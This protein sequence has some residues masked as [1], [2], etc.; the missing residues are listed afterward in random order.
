MRDLCRSIS[1]YGARELSNR[2]SRGKFFKIDASPSATTTMSS[3]QGKKR[4]A[5]DIQPVNY[6]E[7]SSRRSSK[8]VSDEKA[9]K[10]R[11]LAEAEA[12][13]QMAIDEVA[14]L[15]KAARQKTRGRL[16][17]PGA[18]YSQGP[19]VK[20]TGGKRRT[21]AVSSDDEGEWF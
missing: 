5:R 20:N 4:S 14:A 13:D 19:G 8:E 15:E 21:A 2:R 6:S 3:S 9:A 7:T 11:A 1:G 16:S 18:V 12:E 17:N 10:K